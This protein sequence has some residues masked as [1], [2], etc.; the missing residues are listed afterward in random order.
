M[1]SI[2][3]EYLEKHLSTHS[4]RSNED[5]AAI[6]ILETFLRSNGKINTAFSADDKWPNH[7]GTFEFVE[8][9]DVSRRPKQN[10]FVQIK[11]THVYTEQASGGIKYSLKSL[12]FPAYICSNVSFDPGIL[13]VVLN[14]DQR[15][16]ERVFWKYM[17]VSFLNAIKFEQSSITIE[18]TSDD[19]V[20]NTDES[21]TAFCNKI[22]SIVDH[23]SF[24]NHLDS[25]SYSR[26]NIEKII[27]AC[28]TVITESIDRF[29]FLNDSRESVS[30][31]ILT[32]LYDLC[33]SALILN[34]LD[35]GATNVN[36]PLAWEQSLLNIETKYLC[37]FLKGLDYLGR[38]IPEDGQSERLMLKYYDFLWQIRK[39]LHEKFSIEVLSNLE[40]FPLDTDE[41]DHKYYELVAKTVEASNSSPGKLRSSRF[42]IQ[43][44]VPFFVGRERY[45]EVTFQLAGAYAS[46]YNRITAYTKKNI[47]TNYAVQISYTEESIDLWGIDTKIKIITNW[48]V[49]IDPTCLNKLGKII[50]MPTRISSQYGEYHALMAFL[51]KTGLNF[52]ELVDLQESTFNKAIDEIFKGKGTST[53]KDVL[54][55][56]KENFSKTSN[57]VGHNVIRYLLL[58]LR[59]EVLESVMPSQFNR[60]LLCDELYLSSRCLPFERNPFVSNLVGNKTHTFGLV[61]HLIDVA[62]HE[63]VDVVRPY[64]FIEGSTKRTGEIYFEIPSEDVL[65]EIK[66]YN[67]SLDD[68]EREQGY[69]INDENG[70]SCIASYEQS[71]LFIL[72]KLLDL[73]KKRNKGQREYNSTFLKQGTMDFADDLKKLAIQNVFVNSRLLLIY[74]AAGTGKTTLINCISNLMTNQRKLF[75]TKTHTAL[76][77]LK[78]RI[79]NPGTNADFVSI[80]SFTKRINLPDYDVIFV[81]ECSTIDNRTMQV[82]LRKM[83]PDTF[84]VLAGDVHQIESIEFGNWFFYAKE[85]I[86]TEGANVELLSTWRTKKKSLIGLWH[87]VRK[88]IHS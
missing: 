18:F 88:K 3:R 70:F 21:V 10:F 69:Q 42:F 43:K 28:D 27:E 36:L 55:R 11:G 86:C 12:A 2:D 65:L 29:E 4:E 26:S 13:F 16:K 51:S 58:E 19:E 60:K 31:R 64:L 22:N 67:E 82:F 35:S 73:S 37:V 48:Q 53:Y 59:E 1:L 15:G 78:R 44:K 9:P 71:T 80:D 17:S 72:Q 33:T 62:G 6:A 87:E 39:F 40:K 47:S 30:R 74:G 24:I 56:L 63:K 7:D 75:L 23:H 45:Y 50:K 25:F 49:S 52:L 77:N 83:N 79:E 84:V 81:D 34:A 38:R 41:V 61:K 57:V 8:N 32:K 20:L 85:L 14:P 68:W 46:K 5:R 54:I 66:K 76:Q